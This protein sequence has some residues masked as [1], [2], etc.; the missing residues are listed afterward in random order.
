MSAPLNHWLS[1][2]GLPAGDVLLVGSQQ[3]L[4]S[5]IVCHIC[6]S[7]VNN[8]VFLSGLH[9]VRASNVSSSTIYTRFAQLSSVSEA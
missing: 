2:S 1:L 3:V 7:L 4:D 6:K 8:V 9:T 5:A